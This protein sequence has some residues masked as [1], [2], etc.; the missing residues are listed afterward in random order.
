[1]LKKRIERRYLVTRFDT[2]RRLSHQI[3]EELQTRF[4]AD[5]CCTRISENVALAESPAAGKDVF[6][7]APESRGARDYDALVEELLASGFIQQRPPQ[8]AA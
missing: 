3:A 2:R 8:A 6:A 5:I 1:V 4:G 7:H